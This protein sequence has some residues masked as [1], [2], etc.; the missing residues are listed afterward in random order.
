MSVFASCPQAAGGDRKDPRCQPP[1]NIFPSLRIRASLLRM[2]ALL[3]PS[4]LWHDFILFFATSHYFY[5]LYHQLLLLL[6]HFLPC[7][8][9]HSMRF[10][11][12]PVVKT[13]HPL[14]EAWVQFLVQELRSHRTCRV[15]TEK[16][17]SLTSSKIIISLLSL[18][19]LSPCINTID[20]F[21][22]VLSVRFL[23]HLWE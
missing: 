18:I 13:A 9:V 5:Y 14:Q 12:G 3:L 7:M 15:A 20:L 2:K 23:Q 8:K 22:R 21:L 19:F 10:P 11:G 17:K 16:K 6:S 4:G 1:T